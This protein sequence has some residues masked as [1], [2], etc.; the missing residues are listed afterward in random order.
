MDRS[1]LSPSAELLARVDVATICYSLSV[2]VGGAS[3]QDVHIF[4]YLSSMV[5]TQYGASPSAWGYDFAASSSGLP[6]AEA[7]DFAMDQMLRSGDLVDSADGYTLSA[8]MSGR[9]AASANAEA[10]GRRIA[11]IEDVANVAVLRALPTIGRAV[12]SEPQ[13]ARSAQI[14]AVRIIDEGEL[15]RT[16]VNL[17]LTVRDQLEGD[18]PPA[19]PAMLWLD[20]WERERAS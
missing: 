20:T 16:L 11:M 6:F 7:L 13:L 10:F 12:K 15:A 8:G 1:H 14:K 3:R 5:N 4:G 18:F 19:L 17:L 2:S 9:L